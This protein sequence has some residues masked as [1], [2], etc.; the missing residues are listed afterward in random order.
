MEKEKVKIGQTEISGKGPLVIIGPNGAGK[1]RLG[2]TIT[3]QNRNSDRISA[4][5]VIIPP[6]QFS[7]NSEDQVKQQYEK[8]KNQFK[9]DLYKYS[10]EFSAL[11]MKLFAEETSSSIAFCRIS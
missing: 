9:Q 5:R 6:E 11:L 3:Q 7:F 10:S 4:K 8:S 2:V 1:S